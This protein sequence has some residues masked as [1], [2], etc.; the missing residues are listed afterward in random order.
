MTRLIEASVVDQAHHLADDPLFKNHVGRLKSA[1]LNKH[2]AG[3]L[4]EWICEHTYIAGAKYSFVDHEYQERILRDESQ[5]CVIRKCSQVGIS[6]LAARMSLALCAVVP[7]YTVGYTLPT[8]GFATTFMRTRIDPVIQSSPYLSDLVHTTTDNAEVKRLGDSYLYLKGSQSSN[9][10]IS[11]PMDHLVHDE[12]DFSDPEVIGQYQSRLT[13]SKHQRKTKLSTPTIPGRGIDR[14]FQRSRRHFNMVKCSCCNHWFIPDYFEHVKVPD[15]SGDLR[16]ITKANLHKFRYQEAVVA[17]PKC[18]GH[19][20]LQVGYREWV[21]ENPNDHFVA[22]GYQVSP[23]DAPNIIKPSY[24]IKS[25]TEYKRYIDF[26]NFNLGLPAEDKESTLTEEELRELIIDQLDPSWGSYVM[27]LDMGLLCHCLVAFVT[28]DGFLINVHSE[29]IPVHLVRKRRKELAQKF[30]VRMTVVDS[31]PYTE[32]VLAMQDE[33]PNLF[34]AV[35]VRSKNIETHYVREQD[36]DKREAKVEIR[37]VNINRDKAFDALMEVVR[38]KMLLKVKDENDDLWVEQ[39]TDMRRIKEWTADAELS[40]VW[41]KSEEGNDHFHH[42]QLYA[43]IASQI[44]GVSKSQL[45]LPSLVS[46]FKVKTQV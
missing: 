41:R 29:A 36:E 19:P 46:S 35:Y 37:Q 26:I 45:A 28:H 23:F 7:Y 34:G 30:R 40:F 9:A 31:Q 38:A 3:T 24:L 8:A 33:D 13:H 11:V 17:C 2:T 42:A 12:V 43:W 5:E 1:T 20:S 15:Y 4:P 10:P 14:E 18:G 27:G 32:T 39:L 6:E 21:C 22:A 25:S 44:L 16:M